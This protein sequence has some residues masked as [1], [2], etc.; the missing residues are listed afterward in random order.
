MSLQRTPPGSPSV[1]A[2]QQPPQMSGTP[3]SGT[4][5]QSTPT[6][7]ETLIEMMRASEETRAAERAESRAGHAALVAEMH[8]LKARLHQ[9]KA[10]GGLSVSDCSDVHSLPT[11][12]SK[13]KF[14]PLDLASLPSG[15]GELQAGPA[16]ML[17]TRSHP[18]VVAIGQRKGFKI[19]DINKQTAQDGVFIALGK[20]VTPLL[21]LESVF[22]LI[23]DVQ[24]AITTEDDQGELIAEDLLAAVHTVAYLTTW[25]RKLV[26]A[27]LGEI[28]AYLQFDSD[29]ANKWAAQSYG[30]QNTLMGDAPAAAAFQLAKAAEPKPP[31]APQMRQQQQQQQRRGFAKQQQLQGSRGWGKGRSSGNRG[32]GQNT[33]PV[34]QAA[35][36]GARGAP[37]QSQ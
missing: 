31:V 4:L 32:A 8:S 29:T 1:A 16:P 24:L 3:G 15:I 27:R 34:V 5:L 30:P 33:P 19:P 9:H 7:L 11:A 37:A 14:S 6:N 35:G 2:L 36:P 17:D 18:T 23:A 12:A 20:E 21:T 10:H 28:N 13:T 22:A 26:D 25:G